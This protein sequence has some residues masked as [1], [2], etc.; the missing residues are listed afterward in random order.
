MTLIFAINRYSTDSG[1]ASRAI[2]ASGWR[3]LRLLALAV[4]ARRRGVHDGYTIDDEPQ[5]SR[6]GISPL[7]NSVMAT[8]TPHI[9]LLMIG[10]NDINRNIDIATAPRCVLMRANTFCL[11]ISTQSLPV[12][13]HSRRHCSTRTV[14]TQQ[15]RVMPASAKP[16]TTQCL[17]S[18]SE[19]VHGMLCSGGP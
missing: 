11:S 16:G 12:T 6:Q 3:K 5:A 19:Q 9:V 18:F 17:D 10:T 4:E 14:F 7:V 13:P 8:Y 1:R 15:Q 2:G